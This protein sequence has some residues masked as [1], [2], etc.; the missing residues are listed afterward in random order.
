MNCQVSVNKNR[1]GE[2]GRKKDRKHSSADFEEH[3]LAIHTT[4][5]LIGKLYNGKTAKSHN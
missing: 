3:T 5:C 2:R 1:N 4:R